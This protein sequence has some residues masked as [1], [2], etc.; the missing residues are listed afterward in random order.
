MTT[1]E[2]TEIIAHLEAQTNEKDRL[3]NIQGKNLAWKAKTKWYNEGEKSNKYFLNLLKSRLNKI[4]MPKL[5]HDG[6]LIM[7]PEEVNSAVNNYYKDLYNQGT[8]EVGDQERESFFKNMFKLTE[9]EA[10]TTKAPITLSELWNALKPLNDTA[11][12]PDGISHIYLKKLWAILG[13]IILDAWNYSILINK[14]A[15]S[16]EKS[17]LRLI[18]KVGKDTLL[19]TNWR[20]IT[21]S[22][23]DHKLIT[24][25]YNNRL[26]N[27]LG[28]YILSTQTA[29]LK[30]R[31]ITDN[32]RL[33]SDA[34]QLANYEPDIMGSVIALDAQKAFDSV[35]HSYLNSLLNSVGLSEFVPI[36][37]LLYK[38]LT[39]DVVINGRI[40]GHHKVTNGVKQ[41]DALSC[42]LFILAIEPLLRN[43]DKNKEI[44]NLKSVIVDF[45]WPKIY[46]YADDIICV[47]HNKERCKQELFIEYEKFTEISGLKLNAD[48]TEI[49]DFYSEPPQNRNQNRLTRITYL[50]ERHELAPIEVI[51]VN[52]IQ[53]C[54]NHQRQKHLNCVKLLEKMERHFKLWHERNLSLLGKIQI[55]KTFGV[56]Q[57]LYHLAVIEPDTVSWKAI[58]STISKFLWNK[59]MVN[60]QAPARIK[61]ATL[62]APIKLGGFGM[63]DLKEVVIALRLKRHFYLLQH[64]VHPLHILL[65]KLTENVTYLGQKPALEIDEIVGLNLLT[66]KEK[67]IKDCIAP[68]WELESDLILHQNLLGSK[69]I[70]LIRPRK[71][72]SSEV[73]LL[74]RQGNHMFTDVIQHQRQSLRALL[75]IC[76][77][78]LVPVIKIMARLY[79]ALPLPI[80]QNYAKL[81]DNLGSWKDDYTLSSKALREILYVKN[82]AYPKITILPDEQLKPYYAKLNTLSNIK[83]KTGILRLLQGDVY[84][85][86]RMVRFGMTQND[87]CRRCFEKETIHHLLY[88]C[89]Y[90]KEV[91]NLLVINSETVSNILGVELSKA[92]L[93]IRSDIICYLVFRQHVM[94]PEI[95]VRSTLEK[96]A[97]GLSSNLKVERE[98]K[99]LLA[100]AFGT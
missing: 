27:I 38:N 84:C 61:K 13:P 49:F 68:D 66:L 22:N 12:G 57:F 95:L 14:M 45:E 81:K 89:P 75:K 83:N 88:E 56:S 62:M 1:E 82:M 54:Q 73:R 2:E 26:V 15:P 98:A 77:K 90:T 55:Y 78:E 53:I 28:Q 31:N 19:L 51:K 76:I 91:L 94:A 46:G 52:G 69:V 87:R 36:L 34:I 6:N 96:F 11:P 5:L 9:I 18:P 17:Y 32:I 29:Y 48:K 24:R 100:V 58:Y 4:D 70:D 74:R 40:A 8:K 47:T 85:S 44:K 93:E 16:H 42:T 60:N 72:Q 35:S 39:N 3:L 7:D 43:I 99:R 80:F 63:I 37:K 64:N 79:R 67:R 50:G 97:K 23:C 20:P 92:A 21:L 71:L 86:E 59:K 25:V 30:H 33:I 10:D 41:G 65:R